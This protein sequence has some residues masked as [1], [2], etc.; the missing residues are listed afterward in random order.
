MFC[1]CLIFFG[2]SQKRIYSPICH[3]L[4]ENRSWDT[5]WFLNPYIEKPLFTKQSFPHIGFS[6]QQAVCI[7]IFSFVRN[8]FYNPKLG[9]VN[10]P[11]Y[12]WWDRHPFCWKDFGSKCKLWS[13][14]Y[15]LKSLINVGQ[16]A[17]SVGHSAF[18]N[19]WRQFFSEWQRTR[20]CGSNL[21]TN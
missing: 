9:A 1:S 13:W 18:L 10:S 5:Q 3:T 6:P 14:I 19:I 21:K 7:T 15:S 2:F 8:G 12:R 17:I 4:I 20:I 16:I 11:L